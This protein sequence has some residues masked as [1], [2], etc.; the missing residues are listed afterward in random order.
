MPRPVPFRQ[1]GADTPAGYRLKRAHTCAGTAM[2]RCGL[3]LA[4]DRDGGLSRI[5]PRPSRRL[6]EC[7]GNPGLSCCGTKSS[8]PSPSSAESTNFRFLYRRP[9]F[10]RMIPLPSSSPW[11]EKDLIGNPLLPT[12]VEA[13]GPAGRGF[14]CCRHGRN[15]WG[16]RPLVA[17]LPQCEQR[18]QPLHLPFRKAPASSRRPSRL[19]R[20]PSS[21]PR[22]RLRRPFLARRAGSV[23]AETAVSTVRMQ[24]RGRQRFGALYRGFRARLARGLRE[25]GCSRRSKARSWSA[26]RWNPANVG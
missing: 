5:G 14:D 8:S 17:R 12:F 7:F 6:P 23:R 13:V 2:C 22:R 18:F 3:A 9:L 25:L 24:P 11:D 21:E 10:D 15:Q 19:I 20:A 1:E 4:L 16:R 26:N